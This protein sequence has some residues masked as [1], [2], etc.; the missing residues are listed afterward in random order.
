V[1]EDGND[2]NDGNRMSGSKGCLVVFGKFLKWKNPKSTIKIRKIN[3][4]KT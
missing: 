2:G 4:N 1:G 3:P